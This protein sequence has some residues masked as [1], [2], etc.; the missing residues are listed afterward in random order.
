MQMSV[1]SLDI[2]HTIKHDTFYNL[3]LVST[4]I[5]DKMN[6]RS[7]AFQVYSTAVIRLIDQWSWY[8]WKTKSEL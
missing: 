4:I 7:D 1:K 5:Q 2:H 6:L 8:V 3:P